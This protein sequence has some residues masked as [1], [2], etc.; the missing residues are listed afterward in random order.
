MLASTAATIPTARNSR[1]NPSTA[2][3][4]DL[5]L[6]GNNFSSSMA[7]DHSSSSKGEARSDSGSLE[8]DTGGDVAFLIVVFS[9]W[10]LEG[11]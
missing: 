5:E 7:A 11:S 10:E 6:A 3:P 4:L 9:R 1:D 8:L 2:V